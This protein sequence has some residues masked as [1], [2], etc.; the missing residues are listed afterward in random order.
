VKLRGTL[1]EGMILAGSA[2]DKLEVLFV[3]GLPDGAVVS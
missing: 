3:D 2:G 1:S